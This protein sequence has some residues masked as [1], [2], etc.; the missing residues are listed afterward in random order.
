MA[1][2]SL[3]G[4]LFAVTLVACGGGGGSSAVDDTTP[5]P[6]P[7]PAAS[8]PTCTDAA[9]NVVGVLRGEAG[10]DLTD[11]QYQRVQATLESS[12][13]SDGWPAEATACLAGAKDSEQLD[14]CQATFPEEMAERVGD[15][16]RAIL[17]EG[18]EGTS[19]DAEAP[20]EE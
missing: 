16:V 19:D 12:C 4:T 1:R 17:Q 7:A 20:P 18:Q 2:R 3:L 6:E 9:T 15:A 10:D 13:S 14:T 5:E 11:D 8:G